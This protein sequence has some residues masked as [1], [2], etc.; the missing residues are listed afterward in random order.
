MLLSCGIQRND[1]EVISRAFH[2]RNIQYT[3][4]AVQK[5]IEIINK[6]NETIIKWEQK[7]RRIFNY[8]MS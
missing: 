5:V 7:K 6:V 8:E 1:A 4:L 3:P 2:E